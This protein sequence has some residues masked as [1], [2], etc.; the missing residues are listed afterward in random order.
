MDKLN[1]GFTLIEFLIVAGLIIVVTAMT[2]LGFGQMRTNT[3]H[4]TQAQNLATIIAE[5]RTNAIVGVDNIQWGVHFETDNYIL[6]N[7]SSYDPVD[8]D[9]TVYSLPSGVTI[10]SIILSGGGAEA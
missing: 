7:G 6:F 2:A 9:N 5:A 3:Q 4:I 10:S 1:R 8:P